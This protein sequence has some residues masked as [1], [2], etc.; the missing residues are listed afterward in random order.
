M[1]D[2]E[3]ETLVDYTIGLHDKLRGAGLPTAL[4]LQA[5]LRRTQE[6]LR[7]QIERGGAVRLVKGAFVA[8]RGIAFQGQ[9]EIT[10]QYLALVQIMLKGAISSPKFYPIFATHN[11]DLQEEIATLAEAQSLAS[12]RYEFEMLLGVEPELAARVS[13]RGFRVRIYVPC[14]SDW[15]GYVNRRIGESPRNAL[16]ALRAMFS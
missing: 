9:T 11:V 7:R 12:H 1:L 15:W 3:D 8:D 5:Y 14:G 10:R 4:T 13:S 16:L 2:M 6:D